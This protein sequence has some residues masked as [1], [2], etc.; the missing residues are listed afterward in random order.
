[1]MTC[2]RNVILRRDS[3]TLSLSKGLC[4]WGLFAAFATLVPAQEFANVEYLC[5]TWGPAMKLPSKP[6][7]KPQFSDTEQGIYFL[8]QVGSFTRKKLV[9][10][11]LLSGQTTEDIGHSIN[12]YL[13]KMKP[14]GSDKTEIRELWHSPNYPIDTQGY[15]CWMDINEKT[16]KIA[17]SVLFAGSDVTGLWTMNLDGSDFKRIITATLIDEHLQAIDSPSWTPDGEWIVFAD[18]LRGAGRGRIA[19]CDMNGGNRVYLTVG[20]GD[21]QPRLSPDGQTIAY[22]HIGDAK[23]GGLHLMGIDGTN[24]HFLPNPDDKRKGKHGGDSPTWSP[25]GKRILFS[26]VTGTIVE[27]ET[28]K[29]LRLGQPTCESKPYTFGWCHWGKPGIVGYTV[30]GVLLTDVDLREAKLVGPSRL[31]SCGKVSADQCRW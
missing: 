28:G 23:T 8:K 3:V 22:V 5:A 12:I 24:P 10:P 20:P 26:G 15:S 7:E 16:R 18:A 25:D 31:A 13:C 30:A 2:R 1:M 27:A 9:V 19:K 11:D 4:L 21:C 6:R 17:L 29:T 14:D